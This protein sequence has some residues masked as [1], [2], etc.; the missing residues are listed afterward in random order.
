MLTV[1]KY[2]Q[3]FQQFYSA[4]I[5]SS[6]SSSSRSSQ[7]RR[8]S[9]L[10]AKCCLRLFMQQS[11]TKFRERGKTGEDGGEAQVPLS[12]PPQLPT[13]TST[14]PTLTGEQVVGGKQGGRTSENTVTLSL[15]RIQISK[16]NFRRHYQQ[17]CG[18]V[19]Y[20]IT[21]A[22]YGNLQYTSNYLQY[23]SNYARRT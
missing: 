17:V 16:S 19:I 22:V 7:D 11:F 5:N 20:G 15:M 13:T 21:M 9:P 2:S 3:R 10:P 23:E 6:S 4:C 14:P 8:I 18:M 12:V 1:L